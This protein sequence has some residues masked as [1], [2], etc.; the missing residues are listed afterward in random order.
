MR[1]ASAVPAGRVR[2]VTRVV[3]VALAV[4]AVGAL[5]ARPAVAA[6]P[7][8]VHADADGTALVLAGEQEITFRAWAGVQLLVDCQSAGTTRYGTLYAPSGSRLPN[9]DGYSDLRCK[10]ANRHKVFEALVLPEDGEYRL[11]FF[12]KVHR[13]TFWLTM[14][15]T[16]VVPVTGAGG[17]LH[18]RPAGPGGNAALR[19]DARAG[20]HIT[21]QCLPW[22]AKRAV[23]YGPD[24]RPMRSTPSFGDVDCERTD[25]WQAPPTGTVVDAAM[26]VDGAYLLVFD[27]ERDWE[28]ATEVWFSRSA[29]L[30]G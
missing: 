24:L 25:H 19:F 5:A 30:A 23:L 2:A 9:S 18:V 21:V 26:P 14:A 27:Y 22:L 13:A 17:Y 11:R 4:V 28:Q 1:S 10:G 8:A 20:E 12:E 15:D 29:P 7:E 6:A 16:P 3:A